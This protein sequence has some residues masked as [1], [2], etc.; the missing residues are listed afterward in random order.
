MERKVGDVFEYD[1]IVLEVIDACDHES[2]LGCYFD[3]DIAG[4]IHDYFVDN[5]G[6]CGFDRSDNKSVIFKEIE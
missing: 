4:C 6:S 3:T 5:V 1:S 2:C